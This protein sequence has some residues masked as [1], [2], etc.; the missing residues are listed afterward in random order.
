MH[1]THAVNPPIIDRFARQIGNVRISVT[2]RCNF[3]CRYCMPEDPPFSPKEEILTFEE[4]VRLVKVLHS[5]GISKFR[6][7][8]G[9]PT[10]R[11]GIEDLVRQIKQVCPAISVSMTTNGMKLNVLAEK[12]K[13]AGLNAI[14][15]SLDSTNEETFN[16]LIQRNHFQQVMTGI[17]KA[18]QLGFKTKI[19][20]VALKGITDREIERFIDFSMQKNVEVRFIEL[21]PFNGNEHFRDYFISKQEIIDLIRQKEEIRELPKADPNQTSIVYALRNGKARI[22]FIASVTESFCNTCNRIRITANGTIRPC[23]HDPLEEPIRFRMRQGISDEQLL[24]IIRNVIN[25]KWKEHPEFNLLDY[26]PPLSDRAMMLIG[27]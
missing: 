17:E 11:K 27:G 22:G 14:N 19:N 2:D 10:L 15:I 5:T 7:T 20:A 26:K 1:C 12:L 24:T 6:I 3:R 16:H 9:E 8:G 18:L 13:N 25:K 4:I 23:L 21:M